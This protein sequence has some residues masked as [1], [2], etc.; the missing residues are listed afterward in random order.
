MTPSGIV[1]LFRIDDINKHQGDEKLYE[2]LLLLRLAIVV[3]KK[4]QYEKNEWQTHPEKELDFVSPFCS[5][6]HLSLLITY[7]FSG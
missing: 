6:T 7:L 4:E 1:D 2:Q 5:F 3:G